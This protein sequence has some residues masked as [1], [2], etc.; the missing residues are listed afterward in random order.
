LTIAILVLNVNIGRQSNLLK[1][2]KIKKLKKSFFL[3]ENVARS[4]AATK[5]CSLEHLGIDRPKYELKDPQYAS[6]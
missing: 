3:S 1:N 6:Y 4:R 5:K 2:K